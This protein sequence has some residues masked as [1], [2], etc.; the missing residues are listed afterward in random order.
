MRR[1]LPSHFYLTMVHI[2]DFWILEALWHP[3]KKKWHHEML[4]NSGL[5]HDTK[6]MRYDTPQQ[7]DF[8]GEHRF[9]GMFY[10]GVGEACDSKGLMAD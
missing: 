3:G 1:E 7:W 6:E 8:E 10:C 9:H 2:R 5:D 4:N